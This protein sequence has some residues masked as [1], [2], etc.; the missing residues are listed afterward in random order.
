MLGQRMAGDV[1]AEQFLLEFQQLGVGKFFQHRAALRRAWTRL[2]R[3]GRAEHVHLAHALVLLRLLAHLDGPIQNRQKLR[4]VWPSV[5]EN[6]PH[7]I[8]ASM[9]AP[10]DL[11]HIDP[12]AEIVEAG[13]SPAACSLGDDRFDGFFADAAH[14]HQAE[15]DHALGFACVSLAGSCT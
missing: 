14:R 8:S 1:E 9:V 5:D 3:L 6:A 13:E 12:L 11:P 2:C 10:R 15:A 4:R 7:L